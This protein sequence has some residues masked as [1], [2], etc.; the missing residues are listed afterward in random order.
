MIGYIGRYPYTSLNADL[1]ARQTRQNAYCIFAALSGQRS[2]WSKNAIAAMLGNMEAE[3]GINPGRWQGLIDTDPTR[4]YGLVQWRPSTKYTDWCAAY[5]YDPPTMQAALARINFE[6][7][8]NL[9]FFPTADYP[10]DFAHFKVSQRPTRWLAEAFCVNYERPASP[11]LTERGNLAEKW[12]REI[13]TMQRPVDVT[14][15]AVLARR[16]QQLQ[17]G[18]RRN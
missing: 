2:P 7:I 17:M 4:A 14:A 3:S 18:G 11:N 15:V 5:G 9:Q 12:Y 6:V 13:S 8:S 10:I 1:D 16:K